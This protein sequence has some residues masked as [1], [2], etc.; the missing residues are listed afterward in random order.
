MVLRTPPAPARF[1]T[2]HPV[3]ARS[4]T[5]S[6]VGSGA[7]FSAIL[8]VVTVAMVVPGG[9]APEVQAGVGDAGVWVTSAA[10]S[11]VGRVNTDIAELNVAVP[12]R[13]ARSQLVQSGRTVIVVDPLG[14]TATRVDPATARPAGSVTLPLRAHELTIVGPDALLTSPGGG[15]TDGSSDADSDGRVWSIPLAAFDHHGSPP[16]PSLLVDLGR[17]GVLA[18]TPAGG[19][20]AVSPAT[21]ELLRAE[22]GTSLDDAPRTSVSLPNAQA[23][24]QLVATTTGWAVLEPTAVTLVVPTGSIDLTPFAASSAGGLALQDAADP[25]PTSPQGSRPDPRATPDAADSADSVL[26]ASDTSL[27][28]I[29]VATANVSVL[30]SGH[31]GTPVRPVVTG[32]CAFAAWSDGTSWQRCEGDPPEGVAGVFPGL[33]ASDRPVFR[34]N[35]G[36]VVL[37]D[38]VSG[39]VWVPQIG[40][41]AGGEPQG[42]APLNRPIANWTELLDGGAPRAAA[43]FDGGPPEPAVG[44]VEATGPVRTISR[45]VEAPRPPSDETAPG[46]SSPPTSQAG[47]TQPPEIVEP[48]AIPPPATAPPTTPTTPTTPDQPAALP[49]VSSAVTASLAG[50]TGAATLAWA[51]FDG[52]GSAVRGYF[53]Q[54]LGAGVTTAEAPCTVSPSGAVTPPRGGQVVD[55]GTWTSGSVDGIDQPG[56]SYGFIVWGYN[57]AGCSAS[58]VATVTPLAAPAAVTAVIGSMVE[59]G[60]DYDYRLTSVTPSAA[61]YEVQRQDAVAGPVGPIA[62][63]PLA[64]SPVVPRAETGGSFGEVYSFRI[65]AC[66]AENDGSACGPWRVEVAPEASLTFA[67]ADLSYSTETGAWS[68]TSLPQNGPLPAKVRC[69]ALSDSSMSAIVSQTSCQLERSVSPD[70]AWLKVTV[71]GRTLRFQGDGRIL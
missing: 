23:P 27:L 59:T 9:N 49:P 57:L 45:R 11:A 20:I 12:L 22:P 71:D 19:A 66:N 29:D 42:A 13:D 10:D 53:V 15:T 36:R 1:G 26:V 6:F 25:R 47:V 33:A 2:T 3:P 55:V 65:R 4:R 21:S 48:P 52:R 34:S 30:S 67:P 41:G 35:D 17:G 51:P 61:R 24:L 18:T 60:T 64:G 31:G 7:V 62:D 44:P 43:P 68:W 40:G 38:P 16:Q 70:D 58:D 5:R 69:S 14:G 63:V 8:L 39:R 32:G 46:P 50:S 37:N 56:V 28:E 54:S